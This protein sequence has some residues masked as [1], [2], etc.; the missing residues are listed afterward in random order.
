VDTGINEKENKICQII[1]T[2]ETA[3]SEENSF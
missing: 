2:A 3:L 1:R